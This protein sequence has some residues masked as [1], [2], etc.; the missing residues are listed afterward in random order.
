MASSHE[1]RLIRLGNLFR[2]LVVVLATSTVAAQHSVYFDD[3]V[4]AAY[5]YHFA[6]YAE[7]PD[8]DRDAITIAV[9]GANQVAEQLAIFLP[10]RTIAD[11]PVTVTYLTSIDDL[12]DEHVLFI[13]SS[14][15]A[16]LDELIE[17]VGPRHVLIVTDSPEGLAPGAVIN[18]RTI[19]N[20]VRFEISLPAA[21]NVGLTLSSRLLAAALRVERLNQ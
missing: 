4:K 3:D 15:N 11:M 10:G 6:T 7:W 12:T 19:Q 20:R 14:E 8:D 16:R 17:A 18:F 5:L 1:H 21:R 2:V 13:G 9:L